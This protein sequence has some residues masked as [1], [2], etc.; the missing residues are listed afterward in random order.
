[1]IV[2]VADATAPQGGPP[3]GWER[4]VM[5]IKRLLTRL[6]WGGA[7][8]ETV[9]QD[10]PVLP[11]GSIRGQVQIEGGEVDQRV[12]RLTVGVVVRLEDYSNAELLRMDVG[13]GVL[14]G[15]GQSITRDFEIGLPWDMPVTTHRGQPLKGMD[16]GVN[17]QLHIAAAVDPGDF[18][19]VAVALLPAQEAVL[20]ALAA[21]GFQFYAAAVKDGRISSEHA[22]IATT[23]QGSP[24]FQELRYYPPSGSTALDKLD[25]TFAVDD[26]AIDVVLQA[27]KL[28]DMMND[29][30][31]TSRLF[32]VEHADAR[33]TDWQ[34]RIRQWTESLPTR[35]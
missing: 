35:R 29:A 28:E 24:L 13:E 3:T 1:M 32:T 6:G 31:R 27:E 23:R 18:D 9:L 15:S 7:S 14:V 16:V 22:G 2:P 11:G 19:P 12:D 4:E 25:V 34:A 33:G 17:T 5:G 30:V 21:L 8:V 26:T 10:S 20:D